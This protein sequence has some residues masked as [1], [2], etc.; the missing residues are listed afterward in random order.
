M[1]G[2]RKEM[3]NKT[4][5]SWVPMA[6]PADDCWYCGERIPRRVIDGIVTKGFDKH[7]RACLADIPV[8]R[9]CKT[10]VPSGVPQWPLN[11]FGD[12]PGRCHRCKTAD[13]GFFMCNEKAGIKMWRFI[14]HCD[15]CKARRPCCNQCYSDIAYERYNQ[16]EP[17]DPKAC[18]FLADTK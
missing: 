10:K 1:W 2:C 14:G 6:Y 7:C 12:C 18:P 4:Q 11:T 13:C 9:S 15:H 3:D 17:D 8:C 5:E 16:E